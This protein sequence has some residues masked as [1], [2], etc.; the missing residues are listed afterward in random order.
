MNVTEM[1]EVESQ[2]AL[3]QEKIQ[4]TEKA[5]EG[6]HSEVDAVA[7]VSDSIYSGTK[8]LST[9]KEEV[10]EVIRQLAVIADGNADVTRTTN[11]GMKDLSA[12]VD[13]CTS[14]MDELQKMST[15]LEDQAERFTL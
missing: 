7:G 12:M 3:Q 1:Q 11:S 13:D 14:S 6:L 8:K 10:S 15:L 5:F 9:L 4:S 2:V